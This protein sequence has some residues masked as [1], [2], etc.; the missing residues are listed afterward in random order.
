M[1]LLGNTTAVSSLL[2]SMSWWH[3]AFDFFLPALN[4]LI[5]LVRVFPSYPIVRIFKKL[6]LQLY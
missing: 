2:T 3:T 6:Q 1:Y 4:S 5:Q